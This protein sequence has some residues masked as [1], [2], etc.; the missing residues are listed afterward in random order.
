MTQEPIQGL[1][2]V[3][4]VESR[5]NGDIAMK[6]KINKMNQSQWIAIL[7]L[8]PFFPLQSISM[9]AQYN[10]TWTVL[11]NVIAII[12][13]AIS[14]VAVA[15]FLLNRIKPNTLTKGVF[16]FELA[17]LIAC[18]ENDS[19]TF[20]FSITNCLVC[21]AFCCLCQIHD[22][23]N[24]LKF[25]DAVTFLFGLFSVLGAISI[26][27]FPNGF[28]HVAQKQFAIY[29]LGSKNSNFFYYT[30]Y[31]FLRVIQC[32]CKQKD[33][34]ASL[35]AMNFVFMVSVLIC[36]SMNGFLMLSLVF[37]FMVMSKYKI[38]FRKI[39]QPRFVIVLVCFFAAMIPLVTTGKFDW[40][41]NLIGRES[42]FSM[43]TYVWGSAFEVIQQNPLFGAGKDG[44]L[45]FYGRQTHAHN[46][47]I[48]YAAKYGLITLGVFILLVIAISN[49]IRQAKSKEAMLVCAFFMFIMLIHSLFDVM[50]VPMLSLLFLY[51]VKI[52]N[53]GFLF[54]GRT[55]NDKAIIKE[56]T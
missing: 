38:P 33:I 35:L 45:T 46:I 19:L 27:V 36:D 22:K 34:P 24:E 50:P 39:F 49:R 29:L 47:Y 37:V 21:V 51:C 7:S 54:R 9:M 25:L 31:L 48:D 18:L 42:N 26:F 12:R 32:K 11:Y 28:N 44:D 17:I 8:I 40:L 14:V 10:P 56:N 15:W 43:R 16:A 52:S 23:R 3:C 5:W 20:Q 6:I 55:S 30:I 53:Q 4:I 13:C 41:F 2:R 1:L